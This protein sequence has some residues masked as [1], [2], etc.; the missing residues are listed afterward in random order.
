[1]MRILDFKDLIDIKF[2]LAFL[3][4]EE[5][6]DLYNKFSIQEGFL[7]AIDLLLFYEPEFLLLDSLF[8]E[9]IRQVFSNV[10]FDLKDEDTID[11]INAITRI[12]NRLETQP[13]ELSKLM[14]NEYIDKQEEVRQLTFTD[15]DDCIKCIGYDCAIFNRL[16]DGKIEKLRDD[17]FFGA[18]NYFLE[19]I[20]QFYKFFPEAKKLT[21]K[22]L[23]EAKKNVGFFKPYV[24]KNIKITLNNIKN[25]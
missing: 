9:K 10:R 11:H 25:Q 13:D 5:V 6:F 1:M 19:N 24:K 12:L 21:E 18:T 14:I 23:K 8:I 3:S 22:K 17:F 2:A 16:R 15:V 7:K 20:P 4:S